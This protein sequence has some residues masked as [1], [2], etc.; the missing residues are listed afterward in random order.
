MAKGFRRL[1]GD[2]YSNR[3]LILRGRV[4][5]CGGIFVAFLAA[6]AST[7]LTQNGAL[8]AIKTNK[9][10]E[11]G[12]NGA[13][14]TEAEAKEVREAVGSRPDAQLAC[15]ADWARL[16][17][18]AVPPAWLKAAMVWVSGSAAGSG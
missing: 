11:F 12:A 7:G 8:G 3:G 1:R 9:R 10:D 14:K 16:F 17:R 5:F 4:R 13:L 6:A 2:V 15:G 18:H